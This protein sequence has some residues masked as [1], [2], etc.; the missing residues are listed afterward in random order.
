M[1]TT[2]QHTVVAVAII[3]AFFI[4]DIAD[5]TTI[6]N[7]GATTTTATTTPLTEHFAETA[8]TANSILFQR[9]AFQTNGLGVI[10]TNIHSYK[11][12]AAGSCVMSNGVW[13]DALAT[14]SAVSDGF[15]ATNTSH[16]AHWLSNLNTDGGAVSVTLPNGAGVLLS[17]P[18]GIS[19]YD[20]STGSNILFASLQDSTA[21]LLSTN[22]VLYANAFNNIT[23]DVKYTITRSRFESDLI[24]RDFVAPASMGLNPATTRLRLTTAFFS[25]PSPQRT[26]LTNNGE[27]VDSVIDFSSMRMPPG[28]AFLAQNDAGTVPAGYVTK[29][30]IP[31]SNGVSYLE[32]EIDM[33][34]VSNLLQS[35]PLHSSIT[36]PDNKIR[37][38]ASAQPASGR[39][40]VVSTAATFLRPGAQD[41]R[42][43]ISSLNPAAVGKKPEFILDYILLSNAGLTNYVFKSDETTLVEDVCNLY[44]VTRIEPGS[45][46]KFQTNSDAEIQ[47][48]NL[49]CPPGPF[50]A[51]CTSVNDNSCGEALGNGN[52]WGDNAGAAPL[53]SIGMAHRQLRSRKLKTYGF[54]I[55]RDAS[56]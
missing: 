36:K 11:S 25:P 24:I 41:S 22:V 56:I 35:L 23:A 31:G 16:H 28:R 9:I 50:L 55:L 30:W 8:R 45:I 2:K 21:T 33:A 26:T 1:N 42:N 7:T 44:G 29:R 47:V 48:T 49:V 39:R 52:P 53:V 43:A 40:A 38:T 27:T 37:R 5:A 51:I 4:A 3:A 10:T 19:Y 46:L 32:E 17:K 54:H 6:G 13:V 15:A 18:I 34:S 14:V 20:S 12:L